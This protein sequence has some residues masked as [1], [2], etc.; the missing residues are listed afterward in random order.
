MQVQIEHFDRRR[1]M[2]SEGRNIGAYD[3][4]VDPLVMRASTMAA[5]DAARTIPYGDRFLLLGLG[6][7]LGRLEWNTARSLR[8]NGIPAE[9]LLSDRLLIPDNTGEQ[10]IVVDNKELPFPDSSVHMAVTR[11]S[12]HYPKT[13][14]GVLASLHESYRVLRPGG[15]LVNTTS[16]RT[17]AETVAARIIHAAI[18]KQMY[19]QSGEE[20]LETLQEVFNGKVEISS[21]EIPR[22]LHVT[23]DS[24]SAR[25]APRMQDFEDRDKFDLAW[26]EWET[27]VLPYIA[28]IIRS[29]PEDERPN[30]HVDDSGDWN[31]DVPMMT[32]ICRK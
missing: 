9:L 22:P 21:H 11:L 26:Q 6:V 14:H 16:A 15:A 27:V 10:R 32:F 17:E 25:Y 19:Y 3:W 2:R 1:D 7:G 24:F 13:L 18:G 12:M 28:D 31:W 29:V 20:T 5:V 4:F 23:R 8:G 30:M